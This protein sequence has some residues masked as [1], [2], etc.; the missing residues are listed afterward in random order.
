M[1]SSARLRARSCLAQEARVT[2]SARTACQ[3]SLTALYTER[4]TLLESLGRRE[5][6]RGKVRQAVIVGQDPPLGLL[7][8]GRGL[9]ASAGQSQ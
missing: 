2:T 8:Q 3:V 9:H 4:V 5:Q 6:T 1:R 7:A